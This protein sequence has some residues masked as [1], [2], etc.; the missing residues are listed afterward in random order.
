MNSPVVVRRATPEDV[1]L[2]APLF[3]LYRVF[4]GR[5]YDE[6]AAAAYLRERLERD[7]SVVLLA[8]PT[9]AHG[10]AHGTAHGRGGSGPVGFVQL[11]PG[12]ESLSLATSWVL[13]DLYVLESAR[14]GGVAA[15]LME[16]AERLAR[17]AG[18]VS[19]T[20]ETAHENV[21]AQRLYERQ[22]YRVDDTY[23][24]YEKALV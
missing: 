14:G 20:L 11:Y 1:A 13:N 22:G 8:E 9:P 2:V 23:L 3:A 5:T 16:E 17:W 24:H 7:Q 19:L 21:V 6:P 15:A 10:R 18:A 12:Y 4:Y